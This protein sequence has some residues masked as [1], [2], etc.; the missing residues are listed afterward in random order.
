MRTPKRLTVRFSTASW[1][2][3]MFG[4]TQTRTP[5]EERTVQV[6]LTEDQVRQLTPRVAGK[7][8]GHTVYE[9]WE[10]VALEDGE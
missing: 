9:D 2:S 4:H 7:S 6:E 10:V 8:C 1:E 5:A 3:V